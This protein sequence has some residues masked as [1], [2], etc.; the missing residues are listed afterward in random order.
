MRAY[1]V[2]LALAASIAAAPM[3]FAGAAQTTTGSIKSYD[4]KAHS[5]T[6]ADGTV[7]MLPSKAKGYQFKAGDKVQ[8]SW[9]LKGD[10]HDAT[11]V[12]VVK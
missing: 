8:V 4:A 7:Y 6:L 1:L 12:K 3:A 5:I 2:P 11:H 9:I 10:K